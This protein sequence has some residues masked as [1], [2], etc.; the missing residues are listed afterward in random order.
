V[1]LEIP[2]AR[3]LGLTATLIAVFY[4]LSSAYATARSLP[5]GRAYELV[6]RYENG[7]ESGLNGVEAGYGVPSVDWRLLWCY[8]S[9]GRARLLRTHAAPRF[10]IDARGR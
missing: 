6:T 1:V 2:R 7:E 8:L 3:A 9:S 10:W 4:L 5:D